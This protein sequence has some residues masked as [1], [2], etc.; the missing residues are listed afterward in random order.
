MLYLGPSRQQS[1]PLERFTFDAGTRRSSESKSTFLD[2]FA[3]MAPYSSGNQS[4]QH[5]LMDKS[6]DMELPSAVMG[7][8]VQYESIGPLELDDIENSR[9][10]CDSSPSWKDIATSPPL[11]PT[12]DSKPLVRQ[13]H[14][15]ILPQSIGTAELLALFDE[16]TDELP[17]LFDEDLVLPF[18]E[19]SDEEESEALLPSRLL[20]HHNGTK[21]QYTH[22]DPLRLMNRRHLAHLMTGLINCLLWKR[23]CVV[24]ILQNLENQD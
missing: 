1:S 22:P 7:D 15:A 21:M 3:D 14:R 16:D 18:P 24:L 5:D 9:F 23:P 2:S 4:L 10:E 17:A 20:R 11:T 8:L 13:P 6:N 12:N 19:D